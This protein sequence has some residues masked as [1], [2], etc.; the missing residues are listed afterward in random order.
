[1]SREL[2]PA[3]EPRRP[4]QQTEST[5]S[6]GNTPIPRPSAPLSLKPFSGGFTSGSQSSYGDQGK[7]IPVLANFFQVRAIDDKGKI[8]HH[9]DVDINPVVHVINQKKPKAMLRAVW[10]Q[11]SLEQTGDWALPFAACAFDGRRNCYTPVRFPIDQGETHT[12][13]TAIAPDGVVQQ[14]GQSSPDDQ[15]RR[16]KVTIKHVA[17]VDLDAV[18]KFCEADKGSPS[19]EEACMT[20]LMATNVLLRDV[21]SKRYA[22]VG[23]AGNRFFTLEGAIPIAQGGIVCRGFMQ[24]FRHSNSGRPLLNL[25]IGFSA[26]LATGPLVDVVTKILVRPGGLG[27]GVHGGY[28]GGIPGRE[29]TLSELDTR[30]IG[31]IKNKL[32]G[33]KFTVT[34]RPSN[35]LHT[36]MSITTQAAQ[37]ITFYIQS[38][39]GDLPER[40]IS[41]TDYWKEY[42]GTAVTKPRLPCVQYG[43]KAFIPLEFVHLADWN[44]LPPTKLTAEQTTEMIRVSAVRPN[45]RKIAIERWR[46]ELA[47]ERQVKIAAWG[48]EVNKKLV[49]LEARILAPPK[50]LYKNDQ[51]TRVFEGGWNVRDKQAKAAKTP[52]IAWACISFDRYYDEDDMRRYITY[53][54]G[55]F[56]SHGI[57]VMNRKP[58]LFTSTDPRQPGVV[59]EYLQKAARAC[60]MAGKCTPQLICCILPGRDAWLYE[61]IKKA[62]FVDL[63]GPVPTQCMQA[64]KI[65]N[66]RGIASYTGNL[67]MKIQSKLGGLTHQIPLSELPGMVKGKT[68]LLGGDL[69]H[70]P[71]KAGYDAA[72]TVACT[73]ATY[74]ADCSHFSA[75]IRLQQG[76]DEIIRDLSAM[77]KEHLKVFA[78]HNADAFP[79][80]ILIF[81]DGISEGQYAAALAYE[82]DAVLQACQSVLADYRP[83]ILIC[84]CAKRHSTRFFGR[85]VDVDRSGN[86]PPGLVVDRSVTHPYA[87]DFFLQAHGGRVGTARPT[88]Y[89]CLLDELSITPNQ[90]Q[91]LVHSL[92]YSFAR[93]TRSVSVVPVCYI[94][95]LVCQK[96]RIIVHD[97]TGASYAPSESSAGGNK[98]TDL[99][100]PP[101]TFIEHSS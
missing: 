19:G 68:M 24:S 45:E 65:R 14:P 52:L 87:F 32:R 9:Y 94:A 48:L 74:D 69:G 86:L 17:L 1:M 35:R 81:R 5:N 30:E 99:G 37:D 20:G 73:I 89:I 83:R 62:S 85:D 61:A 10:E 8:I 55:T 18:M 98:G 92:C 95:D 31:I 64:A 53:L 13:I 60:Y 56:D 42:Y 47:Y 71:I 79:E 21:P 46:A 34:H 75:Q 12:L 49:E 23:A 25:D 84:I 26:F 4:I 82:H 36:I 88:H 101:S 58:A 57:P 72:P 29:P 54:C 51:N 41:V 59:T 40:R 97:P 50:I 27:Q 100:E 2:T 39:G 3:P 93:C 96:A 33:A 67:V 44:S 22:Q 91:Q 78:E 7:K 90:L 11:L 38:K 43:K 76:R 28:L 15:Y 80:R 63:K 77:I 6:A 66:S 70:P 16:F